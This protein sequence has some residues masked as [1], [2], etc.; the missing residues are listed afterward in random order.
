MK[1][2]PRGI[3]RCRGENRLSGV[4]GGNFFIAFGSPEKGLTAHNKQRT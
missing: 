3:G 4:P 1:N 2:K